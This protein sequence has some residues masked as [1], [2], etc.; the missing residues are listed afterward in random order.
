[1][2]SKSITADL[3]ALQNLMQTAQPLPKP[4]VI[5]SKHYLYLS[6]TYSQETQF[7]AIQTLSEMFE[8]HAFSAVYIV[9]CENKSTMHILKMA[10]VDIKIASFAGSP[11][12]IV[13]CSL[14][15]LY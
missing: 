5:I 7:S 14:Y 9:I 4:G 8:A 15:M 13:N 3:M 1:M 2:L 10:V 12:C 11:E 6:S